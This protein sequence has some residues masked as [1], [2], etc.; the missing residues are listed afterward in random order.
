M[1]THEVLCATC[2]GRIAFDDIRP[3][4]TGCGKSGDGC[5]CLIQT[6]NSG[7]PSTND[8]PSEMDVRNQRAARLSPLDGE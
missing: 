5:T 3:Y 1:T 8:A 7:P 4:C 6:K 2:G